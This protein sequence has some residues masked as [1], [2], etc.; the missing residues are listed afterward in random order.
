[1]QIF[2]A[3]NINR[4]VLRNSSSGG[5]FVPLSGAVLQ[6]QGAVVCSSYDFGSKRMKF[7]LITD[8]NARDKAVGSKYMQ[9]EAGTVFCDSRK[10]LLS[11]GEVN[12]E[13]ENWWRDFHTK[14]AK[15]TLRHY[16]S[17]GAWKDIK[18]KA[19]EILGGLEVNPCCIDLCCCIPGRAAV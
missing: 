12:C 15:Y 11:P 1:M 16:S 5:I 7:S 17:D 19:K 8:V 9:S 10:W 14:G 4:I 6:R 3:K 13:R 2:A 18:R